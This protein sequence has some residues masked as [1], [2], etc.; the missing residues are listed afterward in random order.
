MMDDDAAASPVENARRKAA[1][2]AYLNLSK[3]SSSKMKRVTYLLRKRQEDKRLTED[4]QQF[5]TDNPKLVDQFNKRREKRKEYESRHIETE[6]S[7]QVLIDKCSQLAQAI[8]D[9]EFLV[10][11]TGAGISTAASIPDYRGPNGIWTRLQKGEDIGSHDLTEAEP[12]ITHMALSGLQ[13]VGRLQHIVSQNCDG[14][15]LRSGLPKTALSEVHGNM[16]IEVCRKCVPAREYVRTFDVTERT[17]T[18]KHSTGRRCYRCGEPLVDSIV[19]FGERGKLR[20]PLNWQGA[21]QAANATDTILCIGSSLKVLKKYTW[22]WQM[23]RPTRRRPRLYIVNLQWTPKDKE[24]TLKINGKC[25]DVMQ[26]VMQ[27]L[28][29][30]ISSY[31][32]CE[33]LLFDM[34]TPL[35]PDEQCTIT[36]PCLVPPVQDTIGAEAFDVAAADET[37]ARVQACA[38]D[39]P[40]DAILVS[41][42]AD[43]GHD[44]DSDIKDPIDDYASDAEINGSPLSSANNY[45][46]DEL[47]GENSCDVSRRQA[48]Q[49]MFTAEKEQFIL[50]NYSSSEQQCNSNSNM[51][52]GKE[53]KSA[54]ENKFIN[55]S[56]CTSSYVTS[57]NNLSEVEF[58]TC[59]TVKSFPDD[60]K[61]SD[62]AEK[63][64]SNYLNLN[65]RTDSE[66]DVQS[67]LSSGTLKPSSSKSLTI[68]S[69]KNCVCINSCSK[70]GSQYSVACSNSRDVVS[71]VACNVQCSS[72]VTSSHQLASNTSNCD[73]INKI[74][75]KLCSKQRCPHSI[76]QI[77]GPNKPLLFHNNDFCIA[78]GNNAANNMDSH[79]TISAIQKSDHSLK[80]LSNNTADHYAHARSDDVKN[81]S[82]HVKSADDTTVKKCHCEHGKCVH[83]QLH[84]LYRNN[85]NYS[86]E[87][88]KCEIVMKKIYSSG[89]SNELLRCVTCQHFM[90]FFLRGT[91][92]RTDDSSTDDSD[93]DSSTDQSC[94]IDQ[95][96]CVCDYDQTSEQ[97]LS[98][99]SFS[100]EPLHEVEIKLDNTNEF[101]VGENTC[102][103]LKKQQTKIEMLLGLKDVKTED[104]KD[105]IKLNANHLQSSDLKHEA[106][107]VKKEEVKDEKCELD[108]DCQIIETFLNNVSPNGPT[109]CAMSR[110]K[111]AR[112]DDVEDSVE[113]SSLDEKSLTSSPEHYNRT[114]EAGNG[115]ST[116]NNRSLNPAITL[117]GRAFYG[118]GLCIR[119]R[120]DSCNDSTSQ[121]DE[122][123]DISELESLECEPIAQDPSKDDCLASDLED[124]DDSDNDIIDYT[125]VSL[126]NSQQFND[127]CIVRDVRY[128][129]NDVLKE[130]SDSATVRLNYLTD[131]AMDITT[132]SLDV[133]DTI[134]FTSDDSIDGT[135]KVHACEDLKTINTAEIIDVIWKSNGTVHSLEGN[136]C[137]K[138]LSLDS[139]WSRNF[140]CNGHTQKIQRNILNTFVDVDNEMTV[141]KALQTGINGI[142]TNESNTMLN[143]SESAELKSIWIKSF[144]GPRQSG[145]L[146]PCEKS[147]SSSS[148]VQVT[149]VLF[150]KVKDLVDRKR[151]VSKSHLDDNIRK[152]WFWGFDDA[153]IKEQSEEASDNIIERDIANSSLLDVSSE[154]SN[155]NNLSAGQL[156]EE[157]SNDNKDSE[158]CTDEDKMQGRD[159]TAR[160][161]QRRMTRSRTRNSQDASTTASKEEEPCC[162]Y[163]DGDLNAVLCAKSRDTAASRPQPDNDMTRAR[164]V[165]SR[166]RTLNYKKFEPVFAIKLKNITVAMGRKKKL[167]KNSTLT[168]SKKEKIRKIE[169]NDGESMEVDDK[170]CEIGS[171]EEAAT[172]PVLTASVAVEKVK[173]VT[174]GWYGKGYRK[175]IRKKVPKSYSLK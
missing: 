165:I 1:C 64:Y 42:Y 24:A 102:K 71:S 160:S 82:C 147:L 21:C 37:E 45:S 111:S 11:Y 13:K 124:D 20:W 7:P 133:E 30:A 35:H 148:K 44:D 69:C 161:P 145:S 121:E 123:E 92:R 38:T 122:E 117:P 106:L 173:K 5:L 154:S 14:L 85:R 91:C 59:S 93:C 58:F 136:I 149:S 23:D 109:K 104:T 9:A 8:H 89:S 32:R 108:D 4:E 162:Y 110:R 163:C 2:N 81:Y 68:C 41:E 40:D 114:L 6:D 74:S 115:A 39:I 87:G 98:I 25:D 76:V 80:C 66:S 168:A 15:H 22:L 96:F 103:S 130:P 47:A 137:D 3:K 138:K 170:P 141:P 153:M 151:L 167:S 51:C 26:L 33:D 152:L 62:V 134:D 28:G 164:A 142:N 150:E 72:K 156:N 78:E 75:S 172:A 84:Q 112:S 159:L 116:T 55:G 18:H 120:V 90:R 97:N 46:E 95:L 126:H 174:P 12:T 113:S 79:C 118:T 63:L 77:N 65:E 171:E 155:C 19:H 57:K 48:V 166:R 100:K 83:C 94:S 175:M 16:Y 36:R 128:D 70:S 29:M 140:K 54:L 157:D 60:V 143:Q 101:W 105:N 131:Q 56:L 27:C 10:V 43:V 52:I 49:N 31:N 34:A 61:L 17:S 146:S 86:Y 127:A 132:K 158:D 119:S 73:N 135:I 88:C 67:N 53:F 169:C 144:C 139:L 50:Q 107:E 99:L 125:T 129:E